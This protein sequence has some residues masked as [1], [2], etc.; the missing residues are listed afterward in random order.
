MVN[1][2]NALSGPL[3]AGA[4]EREKEGHECSDGI[5]QWSLRDLLIPAVWW[6]E[7]GGEQALT[8]ISTVFY[9][10]GTVGEKKSYKHLI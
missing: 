5:L 1:H 6:R 2:Y 9:R 10:G 7:Q 4:S 8:H 3:Y